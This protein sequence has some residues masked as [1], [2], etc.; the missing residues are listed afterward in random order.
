MSAEKW[1]TGEIKKN[2]WNGENIFFYFVWRDD[3][4]N[5][6][7]ILYFILI[8]DETIYVCLYANIRNYPF[9]FN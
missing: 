9:I 4:I 2:A 3:T 7:K 8:Y 1:I 6:K 5:I